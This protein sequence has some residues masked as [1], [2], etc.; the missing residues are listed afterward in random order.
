M[1]DE[2]T[3]EEPD[4]ELIETSMDRMDYLRNDKVQTVIGLVIF[5]VLIFSFDRIATDVA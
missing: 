2:N 1:D 5:L 4:N 3:P